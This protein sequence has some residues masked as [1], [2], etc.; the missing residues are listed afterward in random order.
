[1]TSLLYLAL[2]FMAAV[3]SISGFEC[4][5]DGIYP[6]PDNCQCFF[7]CAN[8]TPFNE[9][10][11]PGTFFDSNYLICN[12]ESMVNCGD[13]PHPGSTRPPASTTTISTTTKTTTSST[14]TTTTV[15]TTSTTTTTTAT[16]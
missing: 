13:R 3:F 11:G 9:C 15:T 10:C 2:L 8:M 6:D 7:D 16:T 1:M 14:T 12:Y 4:P 5:S